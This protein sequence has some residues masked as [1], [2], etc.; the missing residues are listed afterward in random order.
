MISRTLHFRWHQRD[1]GQVVAALNE[2]PEV[3]EITAPWLQAAAQV[4]WP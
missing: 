2:N 4:A 3:Q 1:V